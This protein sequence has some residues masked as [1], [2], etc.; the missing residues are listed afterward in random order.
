MHLQ[1]VADIDVESPG[2][3]APRA[4]RAAVRSAAVCDPSRSEIDVTPELRVSVARGFRAVTR[5]L[6]DGVFVVALMPDYGTN[7][8]DDTRRP[9]AQRA[10][11]GWSPSQ[12]LPEAVRAAARRVFR[13]ALPRAYRR[14]AMLTLRPDVAHVVLHRRELP[15]GVQRALPALVE[16]TV[17]RAL[18]AA[19]LAA[20]PDVMP[21]V[22]ARGAARILA[23]ALPRAIADRLQRGQ[24]VRELDRLAELL[25][26]AEHQL[27][28]GSLADHL[29]GEVTARLPVEM[30]RALDPAL[31][32]TLRRG[33]PARLQRA[34]ASR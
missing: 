34:D 11:Q 30:K 8:L 26:V 32:M 9:A 22:A 18:D 4:G 6:G 2:A 10:F 20:V 16:S 23:E 31:E 14:A 33:V 24:R 17:P 25:P 21:L 7:V 13:D 5:S 27:P 12:M 29:E 15:A 1:P 28:S 3:A 19:T